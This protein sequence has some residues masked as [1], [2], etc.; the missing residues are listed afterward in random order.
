[1]KDFHKENVISNGEIELKTKGPVSLFSAEFIH[2]LIPLR[3]NL[4][5]NQ[6]KLVM[7]WKIKRLLE[8]G[9]SSWCSGKESSCQAGDT[10]D[11]S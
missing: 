1:M 5:Q 9:L 10:R 3:N 6:Y 4:Q 8:I 2:H 7:K 11:A